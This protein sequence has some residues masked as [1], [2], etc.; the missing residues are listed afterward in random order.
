M[1]VRVLNDY[2]DRVPLF[3]LPGVVLF[4]TMRLPLHIFEPRYRQ[5]IR[6]ARER[7][8]PIA[9]GNIREG[10]LAEN[11][12][13][14]VYPTLGV[15]FIDRFRELPEGRFLIELVGEARVQLIHELETE[16]PYRLVTCELLR[17]EPAPSSQTEPLIATLRRTIVAIH[18]R[19]PS[20]AAALSRAIAE[21]TD[22]GSIADAVAGVVQ[23]QPELRQAWLDQRDPIERLVSVTRAL[24]ELLGAHEPPTRIMN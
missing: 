12:Q 3:P 20:G 16:L 14:A 18:Q 17:D 10:E 24:Q 21:R 15:G 22:V 5:M 19:D 8:W 7:G 23:T 4:P 13:I 11:G 9:M 1:P 6:D 2:L